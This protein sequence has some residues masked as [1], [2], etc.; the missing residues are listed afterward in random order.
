MGYVGINGANAV[1][2]CTKIYILI[3]EMSC[4]SSDLKIK[5][6]EFLMCMKDFE[7]GIKRK[8]SGGSSPWTVSD[9]LSSITE[10]VKI[11]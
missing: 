5:V 1:F 4:N 3:S 2:L 10:E 11:G 6:F 7:M 9:V 8:T